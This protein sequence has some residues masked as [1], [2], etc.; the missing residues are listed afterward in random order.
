MFRNRFISGAYLS[1]ET[2]FGLSSVSDCVFFSFICFI[3]IVLF[4]VIVIV[5]CLF[6][7]VLT[8]FLML[9]LFGGRPHH[10]RR[11]WTSRRSLRTARSCSSSPVLTPAI[12]YGSWQIL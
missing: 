10:R 9:I 5:V 8:R 1:R 6:I 4:I 11:R 3:Y 2:L 7:L 12:R